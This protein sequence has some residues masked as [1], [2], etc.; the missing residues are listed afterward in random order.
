MPGPVFYD[1][2]RK[3]WRR[4]RM[5]LDITGVL[6][7]LLI[8]F[9][10]VSIVRNTNVPSLGLTE[11]KKPYHALKENQKRKYFRKASTHR[12][13]KQAPSQVQLNTT[14]GIRAAFYVDW[15]AASFSSLKQYYPQIDLLFPEF[16]HVLTEDG[17]IQG[18]T[19]ENK[20]FDVMDAS[21]KVRPV[22]DKLMPYLKAEKAETEVFPLVNNFDPIANEWKSDIGDFLD[23][24]A[25]RA[26][27]RKQIDAFLGSDRYRGLTLDFEEIPVD[28]MPGFEALVSEIYQD[29][30]ASGK[31]LYISVPAKNTDFNYEA[32]AKNSD[33]LILMNYDEHY[34]GGPAGAVASQD[35]FVE[36]LKFAVK[37]VPREKIICAISNYG[38]EWTTIGNAKLPQT[39]HTVST[40]EAWTTAE[41]SDADVELDGDALNPHITFMEGENARHDVW[42]TDGV[43]ALNQMRAAQ[44]L[45]IDTF[46]LWRLGSED[47]SL[48]N[49]WDRPGEQGAPD[50]LKDVPPG[51]DVDMEDAGEIL[52]IEERPAPGQRTIKVDAETGLISEE[53]F[54]KI[55]SPYRIARYGSSDKKIAITFDDGPDP[56]WTPKIM[57][58]LDKYGVKGTFFLIGVQAEKYPGVMKKLYDD[59]HEI[60]NH[61]FTHPDISS[62]SRSYFKTVELNLTERLFAAKLGVKPVLFRPP[63]S[64]DQE[65]DTADQVGPLELAQDMGYITV[66]DKIDTNDWRDDPR[67]TA[68]EMFTEVMNNLPPCKPTNFLTCGNVILMHDGGGDRSETVKALNLIIP[69][70]QA[71]GYKIVP[72]SELLGKT[73]AE[74]MPPISKNERWAAMVASLSFILFGAVSQFI[75]AVFFVGDVL[76]TGRL[77]FIGTLAIYDRIR[78]PRLTADPDYRPAVAVLI[79]AYNEEKVIERTVRSVLDSD[80]PKLRA[81]VI[82]D[83]SKDATVE[84]VEQLF[85]AEIASGKVTLLTKPNSGKAAALNYG[86]EFVTEE[87]FV[88]IDAD[89]II[90][91]DAIGLLVPH[92]QNPKIAAIAGNAKVGNRVNWWTRW[93]ALEYITSQN[94]ERRA[95]D[96]FGAVS[97]VPGA[98]G[99]WRTEA[100]LAAG[101]YHHDTVAEDADLTMALLQ[102]GYRV[103]YEDLALAYTEAPSTANGLMRQRFRW[104]FGI[105]Q[106]VYKHRSAF[107]QG[108]ALGWFALPNVVIFQILLP[109][110]SPFIDL[111]FLFGAGS[112]AWNRYMH[113]ES[114]DPSS[115]HKLVLYFAL[116]LVIDFVASTIAFTLER[117]QPGGQKDFWL[118]AHVWLQRFAYR[119]LFS[120]VLIKTLKRAIEGGEFA[121]DKLERMASVKPVGVHTK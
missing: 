4:L 38:Y 64:I 20:L 116:F 80:Y 107:K 51:Q 26:N 13:T 68:P 5:A 11:A 71:R 98:I 87:I 50:K 97:V 82:D 57:E 52:Q 86:L 40:Q 29:M 66:G 114:T 93:Q 48:W 102:D 3:R 119:Q 24:P 23:D 89:T 79:P 111:M 109:L 75:I 60:G 108:G 45:G 25:S 1:P 41:E 16:L 47:R 65:P 34:P 22:D 12:K 21:G 53:D 33:G 104:S 18:V 118:L 69:A 103:E 37:H 6:A 74:V 8:V 117:R 72:V 83:G 63:Y 112:Y 32:V 61:T 78:G 105:M 84:V 59:G 27:F 90:A 2:E 39:A 44:Q 58:V 88:G 81:I 94:F 67:K 73:R 96:V 19:A 35:W 42:F 95:L 49:V 91:P 113:P 92:F 46:A 76:M 70:M 120:I 7:T 17:H 54:T 101:K 121:W 100:V 31:K 99:A 28:S 77:V 10:I 43:T 14:E 9:F 15:D 115:F 85:A 55:P 36:N 110:V 62:V 30:H 106:S 56:T